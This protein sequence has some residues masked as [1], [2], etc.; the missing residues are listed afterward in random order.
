MVN[1]KDKVADAATS[2]RPYIERAL[3][4]KELHDNVRN[5]YA[6]ARAVY[7]EL[8]SR[9]R[10]SDAAS[11]LAGDK[12]LQDDI[13]SAIDEIRN[14]A[15]RVK[16]VKRSAPEPARAAKNSLFLLVGIFLGLLLNPIT[17]PTLRRML[18]RQLFGSG[19]DF[20]YQGNGSKTSS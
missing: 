6:S 5:A 2:A 10:M 3:R 20:V 13:R 12:D 17:G 14:A 16:N 15:G 4:D 9:R 18:A 8:S 11:Q 1:T 7:D 19:S